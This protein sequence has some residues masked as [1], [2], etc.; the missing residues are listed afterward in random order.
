MVPDAFID[1]VVDG[2]YDI[3]VILLGLPTLSLHRVVKHP[4]RRILPLGF[5]FILFSARTYTQRQRERA[6][7]ET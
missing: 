6:R 7:F 2:H 1:G 4:R 3:H 5:I